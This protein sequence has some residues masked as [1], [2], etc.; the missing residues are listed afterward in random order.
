MQND[1]VQVQMNPSDRPDGAELSPPVAL[2]GASVTLGYQAPGGEDP[3]AIELA[4]ALLR[5]WRLVV[6]GPVLA[7]VAAVAVS[8]VLPARYTAVASFV[9]DTRGAA[10]LPAGLA[11]LAGQF[12]MSLS[13][14]PSQ[15][16]RFY[17]QV[18][19]SRELLER[20]LRSKYQTPG[21]P[22][23]DSTTLLAILQIG[24]DSLADSLARG[25]RKLR[26]RVAAQVDNQT[27]LVTLSVEARDP[28]LAAAMAQWVLTYLEEFNTQT[29]QSRARERR[30]FI[31][32]R[33]AEGEGQLRAAEDQ[34][35]RFNELNRSWQQSPQLVFEEGRLRRQV[36]IRQELYVT[37]SREYETA[38]IEEVNDTPVL[39]VV[40]PP[41]AP[42]RPSWPRRGL[43]AAV[44][45]VLAGSIGVISAFW[46]E[47]L[48]RIRREQ[49]QQ[50]QDF[51][52]LL[53]RV[54]EEV[55]RALGRRS[56]SA[57]D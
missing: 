15:S 4:T 47:H 48:E 9:P 45:F 55:G 56:R 37:L 13:S 33:L 34:L 51:K 38:R 18:V 14:D 53:G 41:V 25:V 40:D 20:V 10:R 54:R 5:H 22:K 21:R 42:Q 50:Y 49:N 39:T 28:I 43:I 2:R 19:Q 30:V 3:S 8:L 57:G 31:E 26:N 27:N 35:R 23:A 29:R 32:G 16:P 44:A 6:L 46:Q 12:G 24:G 7:V 1:G 11:G 17:A 36:E 52:E